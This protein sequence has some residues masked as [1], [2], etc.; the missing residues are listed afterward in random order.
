MNLTYYSCR[1]CLIV[2]PQNSVKSLLVIPIDLGSSYVQLYHECLGLSVSSINI[3]HHLPS[4]LCLECEKVL[5]KFHKF[6]SKC[7]KTEELLNQ[8][9]TIKAENENLSSDDD[10]PLGHLLRANPQDEEIDNKRVKQE[11]EETVQNI[12]KWLH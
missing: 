12:G 4:F 9:A 3:K 8:L 5:L 2:K 1:I 11:N 10:C 6:R 7:L